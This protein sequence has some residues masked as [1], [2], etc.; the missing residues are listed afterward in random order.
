VSVVQLLPSPH[1]VFVLQQPLMPMFVHIIVCGSQTSIVHVLLSLHCALIV[2][3]TTA[4]S[5]V[6]DDSA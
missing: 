3:A 4:C 6:V 5:V 1:S 2:H